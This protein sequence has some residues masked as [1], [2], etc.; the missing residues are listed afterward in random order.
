[1][2]YGV[3]DTGVDFDFIPTKEA[4]ELLKSDKGIFVDARD[5]DD[6]EKSKI[7]TS[8]NFPANDIMFKPDRLD[9]TLVQRCKDVAAKGKLIIVV[10]D[11]GISGMQNRGHVSR[12]RHVAQYLHELGVERES[13]RRLQGGV[14]CWK[15][16][17]LD[18]IL[19]DMRRYYAGAV[20]NADKEAQL[21]VEALADE[22]GGAALDQS[23]WAALSVQASL[24]LESAAAAP[25]AQGGAEAIC[26]V[27]AQAEGWS[28]SQSSR[29]LVVTSPTVYRVLSGEVYKKAS[30]EVDK[31]IKLSWAVDRLVRT[32]GEVFVG[33]SGGRWAELDTGCGE[34]AGWVYIEGPGFGPS[35]RNITTKYLAA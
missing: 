16:S 15:R 11:A 29:P 6:F 25:S 12:C 24:S 27:A 3:A 23:S 2:G 4:H 26:L 31:V 21:D 28:D 1:M 7:Q 8:Y 19:G 33:S 32:T 35:T 5:L 10:S 34:K 20:M 9:R 17:G 22:V 30:P 14:N 13:I 18:G